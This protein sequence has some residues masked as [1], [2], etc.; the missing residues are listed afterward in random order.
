MSKIKATFDPNSLEPTHFKL[1]LT[2][3]LSPEDIQK[4]N[5]LGGELKYDGGLTALISIP[6]FKI[7]EF[8]QIETVLEVI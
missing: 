3:S 2:T 6:A 1:F 7:E 8:A 4:L 5:E